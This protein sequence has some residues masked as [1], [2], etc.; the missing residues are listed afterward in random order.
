MRRINLILGLS[1]T[2]KAVAENLQP[3]GLYDFGRESCRGFQE[4]LLN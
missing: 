4:E 1:L 3:L 2:F